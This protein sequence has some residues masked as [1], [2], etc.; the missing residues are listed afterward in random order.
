MYS[1]P[2]IISGFAEYKS[3]IEIVE[4]YY[5]NNSMPSNM[6]FS[7]Y[8]RKL[9]V[10][11]CESE[12]ESKLQFQIDGKTWNDLNLYEGRIVENEYIEIKYTDIVAD[13]YSMLANNWEEE[14]NNAIR[15][16]LSNVEF[17]GKDYITY[18]VVWRGMPGVVRVLEK[19][20]NGYSN[21]SV[22]K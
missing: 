12:C 1:K 2:L 10:P 4:N 22:Q 19:G 11:Y 14:N 5:A 7:I 9:A 8:I 15:F 13:V 20:S 16:E 17:D 18:R 21:F 3:V 6:P